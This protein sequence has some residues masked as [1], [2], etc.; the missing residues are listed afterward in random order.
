MS[1]LEYSSKANDFIKLSENNVLKVFQ[2]LAEKKE[3]A[4]VIYIMG[5]YPDIVTSKDIIE[6]IMKSGADILEIGIPFSDPMADGPTIQK[7]SES[8]LSKGITPPMCMDLIKNI[9]KDHPNFPILVMTYS[10]IL[11][12]NNIDKFL[13]SAKESMIDGFIIPDLNIEESES[14][15][16]KTSELKL[17]TVFLTAP[18]TSLKRLQNIASKSTGFVYMVSIFGTTGSRAKFE[19][20][21]FK[22]ISKAKEITQKVNTPLLVGFGISNKKDASKMIAAGA[23]GIIV[24]SAVVDIISL[25]ES[26]KKKMLTVL[27]EF[28]KGLK[29]A[30]KSQ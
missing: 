20:Y 28:V 13:C 1:K 5:G 19:G 23:D 18:N 25:Y 27:E 6:T 15:L 10:N 17:A 29:D 30:C 16:K 26:D 24:G 4:L 9:K 3:K 11:Y 8:A 2:K 14:Y 22:A 7:A 21:T 12:G